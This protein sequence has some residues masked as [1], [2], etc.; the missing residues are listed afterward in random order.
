MTEVKIRKL[1]RLQLPFSELL[2]G[3]LKTRINAILNYNK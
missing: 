2:I 1:S 3:N